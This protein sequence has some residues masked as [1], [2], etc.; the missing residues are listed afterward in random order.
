MKNLLIS[1]K[2]LIFGLDDHD[3]YVIGERIRTGSDSWKP[4]P[5]PFFNPLK[6]PFLAF[7]DCLSCVENLFREAK[8]RRI[9]VHLRQVYPLHIAAFGNDANE[10]TR[11]IE[12]GVAADA[13]AGAWLFGQRDLNDEP[14][15]AL[16][17]A[18]THGNLEAM[19]VLLDH[20][21]S[22]GLADLE[23]WDGG[24]PAARCQDVVDVRKQ[25][26][27]A[28]RRLFMIS[29]AAHDVL[30]KAP[31]AMSRNERKARDER[32]DRAKNFLAAYR[33]K[34]AIHEVM[35]VAPVSPR[36]KRL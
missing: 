11:L 6:N 2:A 29:K 35:D 27:F 15:T 34:A 12:A 31:D 1:I 4:H 5:F 33:V 13:C 28:N 32:L 25:S 36:R 10:L 26:Y 21:A 16:R 8:W 18:A 24:C 3:L 14:L 7:L 23:P 30:I 19:K 20:G 22:P 9:L 17:V